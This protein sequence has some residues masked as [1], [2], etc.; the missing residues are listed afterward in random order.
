MKSDLRLPRCRRAGRPGSRLRMAAA[1][2]LLV[3][4]LAGS[5]WGQIRGPR[6]GYVFDKG[7]GVLRP[8]LG[9]PGASRLGEPLD[10]GVSLALA[11]ISPKQDYA[12]GITQDGG[13][14]VLI[15]FGDTDQS[16]SP[17]T[18]NSAG[19]GATSITLSSEGKSAAVLYSESQSLKI[20]TG[21]PEAPRLLSE[22]D[23]RLAGLPEA[24][25]LDDEGK[26]LVLAI[27]EYQGSRISVFTRESGLQSLGIFGRVSALKLSADHKILVADREHQEVILIN[28]ALGSAQ[29]MRIATKVDGIHDPVAVQ[30]SK[31]ESRV[32]VA[33]A[34]S[35][36]V[37]DLDL[38][39]RAIMLTACQCTPTGLERLEGNSVFR[40]TDLSQDPLILLESTPSENRVL[41][42]PSVSASRASRTSRQR[43]Q[44]RTT[45]APRTT[46]R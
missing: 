29:P 35:G 13:R 38:G 11:A 5:A 12:L 40:L 22:V 17:L 6:L 20:L 45:R 42:V 33:N 36:T 28:D 2:S 23:L 19:S 9:V 34:G 26:L 7:A 30:F 3:G 18:I 16:G 39:G 15:S 27:S 14:L 24:L 37:A 21:L 32:F 41:F 43:E 25:A 1:G 46:L 8:I 10:L 44:T 4:L 31:D